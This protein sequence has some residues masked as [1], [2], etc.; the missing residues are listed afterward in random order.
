MESENPALTTP[1]RTPATAPSTPKTS[2]SRQIALLAATVLLSLT[3]LASAALAPANIFAD[4]MVLQADLPLPIWGAA[5]PNASVTIE[6][7]NLTA[8]TKADVHGRW[9]LTFPSQ[10]PSTTGRN[11]TL[12]SGD[13]QLILHDILIG[14]VWFASGQ[15]NMGYEAG[16]VAGLLPEAKALVDSAHFPAIRFRRVNERSAPAPK[17][18]LTTRAPWDICS[19]PSVRKHSAV[20]FLFAR[21]LH[22]DLNIPVGVIDC[23]QGGTPIEPYIPAFAFT[24]HPTLEKLAALAKSGDIDAIKALPGGTFVR[25]PAWL[26][27]AIYNSRIAPVAPYAIRGAIWYQGES[28]SGRGED[29]RDYA[30]KMRALITGW[31]AV[32]GRDDLPFYYVQLPQRNTYARTWLREEQ[33]RALDVPCTGM[34]VTIDLVDQANYIHPPNK[35][36]IAHR[37]ARWALAKQYGRPLPTSGPTYRAHTIHDNALI[38]AFDHATNGLISAAHTAPDQITPTPDTP[39]H[40]FEIAGPDGQWSPAR[41]LIKNNTIILTSPKVSHPVAARYACYPQAPKGQPPNL[42]NTSLLP[43]SPFCTDWSLMPYEPA[44]NALSKVTHR[45][46]I[47]NASD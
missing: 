9:K 41:A 31:R 11:M 14:E 3:P 30:Y 24:G 15:S 1:R 37:L 26:A 28:N 35:I 29:P 38:L 19:P 5:D 17:P 40:G 20:A 34:V 6:F 21:R 47:N 2:T 43:A 36:A 32:W 10:K 42:Y 46:S 18:D 44:R 22:Q 33:R 13:D 16:K 7:N 39:L 23:S 25:S 4:H 27:G 45:V 8:T 12:R